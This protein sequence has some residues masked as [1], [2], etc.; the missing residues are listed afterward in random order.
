LFVVHVGR[1]RMH[2]RII[3]HE[4]RYGATR[5][6]GRDPHGIAGFAQMPYDPAT[7]KPGSTK[8]GDGAIVHGCR[9]P[10]SPVRF[11]AVSTNSSYAGFAAA[12]ARWTLQVCE[13]SWCHSN[14]CGTSRQSSSMLDANRDKEHREQ[15][16]RVRP[17]DEV[18]TRR[19]DCA[20][21]LNPL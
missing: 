6:P 8:D 18:M 3:G 14:V 1:N 5:M 2:S 12:A 7:K 11:E 13:Y 16:Q 19:E 21:G 4:K 10:D 15:P 9:D 17:R 20:I